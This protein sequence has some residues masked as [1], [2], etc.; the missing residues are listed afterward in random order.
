M[1]TLVA[2]TAILLAPHAARAAV[3]PTFRTGDCLENATH[4]VLVDSSGTVLE[5][6][7]GDLK[8][9]AKLPLKDFKITLEHYI[10]KGLREKTGEK[11]TGKRLVLFLRNNGSK[12]GGEGTVGGW[13]GA[14]W[15]GD[16]DVSTVWV[17]AGKPYALEQ[18]INPGPH[19]MSPLFGPG[20]EAGLKDSVQGMNRAV[21]TRLDKARAEKDLAAR[22]KL[23]ANIVI[24]T[25]GLAAPAFAGLEW[26][27][28]DA[29]PALRSVIKTER[30]GYAE[31]TAAY[32]TL[33]VIGEPARDELVKL[34]DSQLKDWK[35]YARAI[36]Y[37]GKLYDHRQEVWYRILDAATSNPGAFANLTDTQ[38]QTV[39]EF[40][41]FWAKHPVLSKLGEPGDRIQ[42]RLARAL[43]PDKK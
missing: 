1:R 28:A 26:C 9:G 36:E 39:R 16:F 17:E 2:L 18:F 15:C 41:D 25:P 4:V 43:N 12:Y 37:S 14:H 38:R 23:L 34:L 29:V 32:R 22:A 21:Q 30:M 8:P 6:W 13:A 27:G 7:R 11:V 42:D 5:S 35:D 24:Q 19:V 33:A 40:R 10:I 31:I 20:T 3:L